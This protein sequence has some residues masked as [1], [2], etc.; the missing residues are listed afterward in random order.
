[1]QMA[2]NDGPSLIEMNIGTSDGLLGVIERLKPEVYQFFLE[3]QNGTAGLIILASAAFEPG[4]V[5]FRKLA[6]RRC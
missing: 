3:V 1:M 4:V 2:E 6:G 5:W